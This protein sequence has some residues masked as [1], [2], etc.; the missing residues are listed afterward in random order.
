MLKLHEKGLPKKVGFSF[1]KDVIWSFVESLLMIDRFC[2]KQAIDTASDQIFNGRF[3][4]D[5]IVLAASTNVQFHYL[6]TPFC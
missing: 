4:E 2:V 1:V 5:S 6:T 3:A